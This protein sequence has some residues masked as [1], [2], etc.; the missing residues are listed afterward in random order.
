MAKKY[1][2]LPKRVQN[3]VLVGEW[4][5]QRYYAGTNLQIRCRREEDG[6]YC[7][8]ITV[9]NVSKW[10]A[11]HKGKAYIA[12]SACKHRSKSPDAETAAQVNSVVSKRR[13][14]LLTVN[15]EAMTVSQWAQR[16][17]VSPQAIYYRLR[18]RLPG[19]SD[20]YVV[21]GYAGDMP[22]RAT[23]L[24]RQIAVLRAE[25]EQA[26]IEFMDRFTVERLK[27][28]LASWNSASKPTHL[29]PAKGADNPTITYDP[30]PDPRDGEPR[31]VC[32]RTFEV[33]T[34]RRYRELFGDQECFLIYELDPEDQEAERLTQIDTRTWA[35]QEEARLQEEQVEANRLRQEWQAKVK[36]KQEPP[37]KRQ[38]FS[39]TPEERQMKMSTHA[40]SS[41]ELDPDL[42]LP[43]EFQPCPPLS[44]AEWLDLSTTPW[45][46]LRQDRQPLS[47]DPYQGLYRTMYERVWYWREYHVL[48]RLKNCPLPEDYEGDHWYS[49]VMMLKSKF[50]ADV[51]NCNM[52]L[53]LIYLERFLQDPNC[54][55]DL[56]QA[57]TVETIRRR[58]TM[59]RER[60]E[61]LLGYHRD[62]ILDLV[63]EARG[64]RYLPTDVANYIAR[65]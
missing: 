23:E 59:L 29:L 1:D 2:E 44:E 9:T 50:V 41:F 18:N 40:E 43:P 5:G 39:A 11:F 26:V 58:L 8:H 65:E 15:D 21:Y 10:N 51:R 22:R 45:F 42:P 48:A 13:R 60:P 55:P 36:A 57:E 28:M 7:N 17:G 6:D 33:V 56:R 62:R 49:T 47:A 3:F 32:N 12:C 53:D 63:D 25:V 54:T 19:Q 14:T 64:R 34:V 4:T 46:L 24:D 37:P 35:E 38:Y 52:V 30:Q 31:A 27:P 16:L 20:A 61:H